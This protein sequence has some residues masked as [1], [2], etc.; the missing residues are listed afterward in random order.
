MPAAPP[1]DEA[2]YD[3]YNAKWG[4]THGELGSEALR[5]AAAAFKREAIYPSIA[6]V[7]PEPL[8]LFLKGLTENGFRFSTW[9][10]L[11]AVAKRQAAAAAEAPT[12]AVDS[13]Q[14]KR[15]EQR[16]E[17]GQ[18]EAAGEASDPDADADDCD[19]GE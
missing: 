9:P 19:R 5:A 16:Q 12:V 14:E 4:K 6:A 17:G 10:A 8:W 2:F 18:R 7:D 3:R 13:Q 1:Q 11:A 15:G